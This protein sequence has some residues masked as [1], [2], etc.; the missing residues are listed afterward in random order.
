MRSRG[1]VFG[2]LRAARA[3]RRWSR[4][5]YVRFQ[6]ERLRALVRHARDRVP[7]FRK[8]YGA[9]GLDPDSVRGVEDIGKIPILS[10]DEII[11]LPT[12]EEED[13]QGIARLS[14][15]CQELVHRRR[16][17]TQITLNMAPFVPK[18]GTPCQ[19]LPMAQPYIL[20]RRLSRLKSA[21][22]PKG[23]KIKSESPAWS[24]IQAVLAR[25][26]ASVAQVLNNVEALSLAGWR[27]A[28]ARCHL[29]TDYYAHQQWDESQR[30]PWAII[31][32]GTKTESR[33]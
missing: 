20:N 21:L 33:D 25:G 3:R 8:K 6:G 9:A 23:I 11:G 18:A 19:W 13:V 10:R 4:D 32:T 22:P 24:Q 7:F 28:V 2:A 16:S 15:A 31:D 14:Q 1:R 17:L 30:L 26:D 27:E 5:D 12:E 29:D